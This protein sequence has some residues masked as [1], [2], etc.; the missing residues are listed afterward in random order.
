V[1][2]QVE[3]PNLGA[4]AGAPLPAARLQHLGCMLQHTI[5]LALS[6][7]HASNFLNAVLMLQ[8]GDP[9]Q[10]SA[11][12]HALFNE[13]VTVGVGGNLRKMSD[14]NHLVFL[15][16]PFQLL[17]HNVGCLPSDAGVH[18]IKN[19][20]LAAPIKGSDGLQR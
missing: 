15:R 19:Q 1:S 16:Q 10:G 3:L 9:R 18:F 14:T 7:D 12:F 4:H 20:A 8:Q 2:A 13:L 5:R 6:A 17:A 11:L